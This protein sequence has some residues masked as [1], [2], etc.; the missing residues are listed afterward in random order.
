[1]MMGE[2]KVRGELGGGVREGASPVCVIL[3]SL[4]V[5]LTDAAILRGAEHCLICLVCRGRK[6][7]KKKR[8]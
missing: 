7:G 2:G 1:M 6:G 5:K 4:K 8:E 3:N